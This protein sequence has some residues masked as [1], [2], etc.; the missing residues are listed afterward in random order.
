MRCVDVHEF[1]CKKS[2]FVGV[3]VPLLLSLCRQCLEIAR[4]EGFV[5][6]SRF[7]VDRLIA[8]GPEGEFNCLSCFN[9]LCVKVQFD[10]V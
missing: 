10:R 6:G 2:A 5:G 3:T 9:W 7:S 8:S 1:L 4:G